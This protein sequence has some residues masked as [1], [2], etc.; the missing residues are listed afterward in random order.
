MLDFTWP[1]DAIVVIVVVY[2]IALALI[3]VAAFKG[4]QQ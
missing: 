3:G 1:D 4:D 2:V